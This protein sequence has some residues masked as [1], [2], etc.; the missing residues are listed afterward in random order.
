M[1]G[2]SVCVADKGVTHVHLAPRGWCPPVRHPH[3]QLAWGNGELVQC[4]DGA[5]EVTDGVAS[6]VHLHCNAFGRDSRVGGAVEELYP[7]GR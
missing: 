4:V 6:R 2:R 1:I 5:H 3:S 7:E